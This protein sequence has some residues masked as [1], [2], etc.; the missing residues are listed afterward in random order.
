MRILFTV[1]AV[2]EVAAGVALLASPALVVFTLLGSS[3]D[4]P[5]AVVVARLT[6]AA[7][8]SI[9]VAAWAMRQNGHSSTG[10]GVVAALLLY[11]TAAV[12]LFAWA[13]LGSGL[14]GLGLWPVL[15]VHTTM[16]GWC[17]RCLQREAL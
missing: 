12:V 13:R 2:I 16:A 11:N 3:L 4:A 5:A 1:T 8:L 9:G 7:L 6:G 17:L 14:Q 15:L 10:R